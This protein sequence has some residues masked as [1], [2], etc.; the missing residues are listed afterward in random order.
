MTVRSPVPL[1]GSSSLSLL[2]RVAEMTSL[3]RGWDQ[4]LR[5]R[6]TESIVQGV[7]NHVP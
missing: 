5:S 2:I 3:F 4:H 1:I 7:V 6:R